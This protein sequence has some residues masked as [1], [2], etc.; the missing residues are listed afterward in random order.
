MILHLNK[1]FAGVMAALVHLDILFI[2]GNCFLDWWKAL[3]VGKYIILQPVGHILLL[4]QN[5]VS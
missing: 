2:I 4:S 1:K 3:G 5:Q